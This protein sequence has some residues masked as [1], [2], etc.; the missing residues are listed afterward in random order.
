MVEY[1]KTQQSFLMQR[2]ITAVLFGVM[3]ETVT[4]ITNGQFS[5]ENQVL[6][7]NGEAV[8]DNALIENPDKGVGCMSSGK[9]IIND[10]KMSSDRLFYV[11]NNYT[12]KCFGGIY[13][14]KVE[15]EFLG[16]NCK[17]TSNND[18]ATSS[19]YPY[20]VV[21]SSTDIDAVTE[22]TETDDVHFDLN[23]MI[24]T[25]SKTGLQIIH[26]SNGQNVKV[27]YR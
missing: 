20:R 7:F 22:K 13:S 4:H 1:S 10:C 19:K 24:R 6:T 11:Y 12:L 21:N 16:T 27:L 3:C 15:D 14:N 23:G 8:I 18:A 26:K 5:S 25:E 9:V 17:C 2:M